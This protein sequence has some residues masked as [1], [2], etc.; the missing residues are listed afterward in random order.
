MKRHLIS[1]IHDF[2]CLAWFQKIEFQC[3]CT[4]VFPCIREPSAG[5]L[6]S[7]LENEKPKMNYEATDPCELGN[8][9]TFAEYMDMQCY[10]KLGGISRHLFDV[11][12]NKSLTN[13][14]KDNLFYSPRP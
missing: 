12:L 4:S 11:F 9:E 1:I 2:T 14:F 13:I 8:Y 10:T 6:Q 7:S 5:T 3:G